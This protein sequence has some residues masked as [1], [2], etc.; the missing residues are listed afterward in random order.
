[1]NPKG[2]LEK[3]SCHHTLY[4]SEASELYN[5]HLAAFLLTSDARRLVLCETAQ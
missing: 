5:L 1:M 4:G 3:D 2:E